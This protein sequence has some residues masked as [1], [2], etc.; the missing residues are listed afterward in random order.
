MK[1]VFLIVL[2][3]LFYGA[4]SQKQTVTYSFAPH[5]QIESA[6]G[7]SS[8]FIDNCS[9]VAEEGAPDLPVFG[10]SILL[11]P[12]CE[13]SAVNVI[14]AEYYPSVENIAIRPSAGQYPISIGT[15]ENYTLQPKPEIYTVNK[16]YPERII[17]HEYTSFY[18][19]YALGSFLINPVIYNPVEKRAE[20]IKNITIEIVSQSTEKAQASLNFLRDDVATVEKVKTKIDIKDQISL[21]SYASFN[22]RGD[23]EANYDI[24]V[25][26]P[27]EF[28]GE[29]IDEYVA[30]KNRWGYKVIVRT[31]EDIKSAYSGIDDA[32]KMRNCVI[33]MYK[34]E[35]ISYLMLFGDSHP[36]S[37]SSHH[38]LPYRKMYGQVNSTSGLMTDNLPSDMYFACLDGNWYD[39][40]GSWGKPEND[41]LEHEISVGRLC[42][43]SK[44]EIGVF[45]SKL[46]KYQ[47]AP[48]KEDVKKAFM[49]GENLNANPVTWGG[50]CKDE[51]VTGGTF[52]Q[53]TTTGIPSYYTVSKL[54]ERD[55]GNWGSGSLFN[56]F[57]SGTHL[58]NH[59]GHS[60][61]DYNMKIYTYQ[62][63]NSNFTNDGVSK[64][65][66]ILYSQGCYNGSF[67][68]TNDW[69]Q[70]SN[71]DCIS[72][73]FLKLTGGFVANIGNSRYGWYNPGG[74][75]GASQRF[76]R[77]FFHAI[78][79]ENI[80]NIGDVNSYSKDINKSY[81]TGNS[82]LR[83]CA[84]ELNLMGDP[85]MDIWTNTPTEFDLQMVNAVKQSDSEIL[86]F[87]NEPY[88]RVAVFNG[89]EFITRVVCNEEG[90]G[91]IVFDETVN[92]NSLVISITAHNKIRYE[93][94]I[95][96][97]VAPPVMDLDATVDGIVVSLKWKKPDQVKSDEIKSYIIYRNGVKI[98][99]VES[100][101]LE[102]IDDSPLAEY[103]EYT[104]CI[105]VEYH[106]FSSGNTCETIT[107]DYSCSKISNIRN[108]VKGKEVSI[109][110]DA[111]PSV[112]PN[113]YEIYRNDELVGET[114]KS[115][116][117]ETAPREYEL[118]DYCVVAK[119]D[120]CNSDSV[121]TRL[122]TQ[123]I[124]GIVEGLKSK[125]ND[126]NVTLTW[127]INSPN[128]VSKYVIEK[129]GEV[130]G[131]TTETTF[132]DE[133]IIGGESNYC[134]IA[135]FENCESDPSCHAVTIVG[136]DNSSDSVN[137][138][139]IYPNPAQNQI[140]V[141]GKD[142]DRIV[143]F[144]ISGRIVG[145]I[146]SNNASIHISLSQYESGI[147]LMQIHSNGKQTVR[148]FSVVK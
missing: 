26:A 147:Y 106:G 83:W 130:I 13:I 79:E 127:R 19:G 143:I 9:S 145:N 111:P 41:D 58:V 134:I 146:E 76:D 16:N 98:A 120:K 102:F 131:E 50:D 65:L 28:L 141:A 117:K 64:G 1:K 32:E 97:V 29:E 110:W 109:Y 100:E 23:N 3:C 30:L 104:Y 51:I 27:Q 118:Y 128:T 81:I 82:A 126:D 68:N 101:N 84:Y 52:N 121:C 53:Y 103:T 21:N 39:G 4:F 69:G 31:L 133:N 113:M 136:I 61:T 33:D 88:A 57:N 60:F 7:F 119:Y 142:I 18:R 55:H 72:E 74:T 115:P 47:D 37:N 87:A 70:T 85:S 132:I 20:F 138:Y 36:A 148:R 96:F 75:N 116:Y 22:K 89:N 73:A 2:L 71:T 63:T 139:R 105:R 78:F 93:A 14:H 6:D 95:D 43:D 144:D 66:A 34:N 59:L 24:L 124:C 38:K 123:L 12:G 25:I 67:D 5:S 15:P 45:V 137:D 108:T 44:A 40:N 48:I 86:I 90:E 62:V 107:T 135:V 122:R 125:I 8:I 17:E 56:Y 140:T 10:A 77:Y 92:F 11:E 112:T 54:Y 35:G 129:N 91:T 99:V 46:I 49:V 94:P 80:F 114:A 42:A